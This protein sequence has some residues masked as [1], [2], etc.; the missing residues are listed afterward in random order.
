MKFKSAEKDV[1]FEKWKT[2]LS[3][4]QNLWLDAVFQTISH[5]HFFFSISPHF[6]KVK[7]RHDVHVMTIGRNW[8][9]RLIE[10]AYAYKCLGKYFAYDPS[11]PKKKSTRRSGPQRTW[12]LW[13]T[14]FIKELDEG[15]ALSDYEQERDKNIFECMIV[16]QDEWIE[17]VSGPPRWEL[18]PHTTVKMAV[19]RYLKEVG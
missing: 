14:S 13:G 12:K 11:N 2:P 15:K 17:F 18:H 7:N 8:P 6:E 1:F 9:Y 10:E 19:R 4:A 3:G 5:T 16:T